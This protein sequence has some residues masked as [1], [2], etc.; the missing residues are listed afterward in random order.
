MFLS[1]L[2]PTS[3]FEF[4]CQHGISCDREAIDM[5]LNYL[6]DFD[7]RDLSVDVNGEKILLEG[8]V[9]T[10]RDVERAMRVASEIT[11]FDR[12]VNRLVSVS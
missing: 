12:I 8:A 9:R 3:N 2:Q 5:E 6:A 10:Q 4:S 11:G 7:R 1:N